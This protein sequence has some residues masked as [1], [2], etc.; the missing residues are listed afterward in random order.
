VSR[1]IRQLAVLFLLLTPCTALAEVHIPL[2]CRIRNRPP[3]RCGWCA[4]ETLARHQHVLALYGITD[5]R[6]SRCDPQTLEAALI[7]K[8]LAYRIQSP[9]TSDTVILNQAMR[10][11]RGVVVGFRELWPGAGG[12]I[13][14]LVDFTADLVRV[15]D[16]NDADQRVRTMS[17]NHFLFW[18][19]GFAMVLAEEG[20]KE[21]EPS[22]SQYR[23]ASPAR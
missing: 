19:D 3:G 10:E 20:P 6:N 23:T 11:G 17:I 12:H 1:T 22:G 4:L 15:I 16:S 21:G 2:T 5:E 7:A 18:W 13:V 8:R 14:T 9:G